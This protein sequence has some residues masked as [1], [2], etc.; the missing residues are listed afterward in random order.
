MVCGHAFFSYK[1][2]EPKPGENIWCSKCQEYS[3]I[4]FPLPQDSASSPLPRE[5]QWVCA[6]SSRC[7][8]GDHNT[9]ASAELA[10]RGGTEHGRKHA[11]HEIWL[12]SPQGVVVARWSMKEAQTPLFGVPIEEVPF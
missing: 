5:W 11:E 7:N 12:I 3:H 9:G 1:T 2:L 4:P 8:M 10:L 6:T